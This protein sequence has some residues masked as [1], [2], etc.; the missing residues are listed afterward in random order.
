MLSR[1]DQS[2]RP[3]SVGSSSGTRLL[4]PRERVEIRL[5]PHG[6]V[7]GLPLSGSLAGTDTYGLLVDQENG[8]SVFI[9]WTSVLTVTKRSK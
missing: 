8:E 1:P 5:A 6:A 9:P 7:P 3:A 2:P 4:R